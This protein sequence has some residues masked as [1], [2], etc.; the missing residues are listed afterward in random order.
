MLH[1]G[2]AYIFKDEVRQ[3]ERRCPPGMRFYQWMMEVDRSA[4]LSNQQRL[5]QLSL[6][7][8]SDVRIFC[9]HDRTEFRDLTVK[10]PSATF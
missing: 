1:A 9:A 3:A 8:S 6:E 5:R 4:R 2:D 7:R 10:P